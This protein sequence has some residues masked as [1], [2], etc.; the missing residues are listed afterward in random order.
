MSR[1]HRSESPATASLKSSAAR[2]QTPE[3]AL[4]ARAQQMP[5]YINPRSAVRPSLE[6]KL[7]LSS[8]RD[9]SLSR[10]PSRPELRTGVYTPTMDQLLMHEYVPGNPKDPLDVEVAFIVNSIAH[11]LLVKHVDPPLRAIPKR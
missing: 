7:P 5:F 9:G 10:T 2:A 6:N 11:G 1:F 8:F 4:R 3:S